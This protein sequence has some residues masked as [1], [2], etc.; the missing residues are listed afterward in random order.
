MQ[1]DKKSIFLLVGIADLMLSYI[2]FTGQQYFSLLAMLCIIGIIL[3]GLLMILLPYYYR[4]EGDRSKHRKQFATLIA[5]SL[6]SITL[7]CYESYYDL[8]ATNFS[9][10][11]INSL[12]FILPETLIFIAGL[13]LVKRKVGLKSLKSYILLIILLLIISNVL[14]SI[15]AYRLITAKWLGSDEL[16][17]N[18]YASYLFVH[19]INPYT[20]SMYPVLK[21]YN[22]S[23]TY[24]LNGSCEC[25]YGY[26]AL[27]FILP[28]AITWFS[29]D[30]LYALIFTTMVLI[31]F[32]TYLIYKK[33]E[34]NTYILLPIAAW[35][36]ASSYLTPAPLDKYL[37][38]SLFLVLAYVFRK[39][40]IVSSILSGLAASTHPISWF[41]L[42]FFYIMTLKESGKAAMFRSILI[43]VGIFLMA[44]AY[45]IVLSP[46][47]TISSMF[48]LFFTRLQFSGPSIA[49]ILVAF[50]P[51]PYWY[52][53]LITVTVL[54]SAL[55]L[56][57]LYTD[58][59]RPLIAVAPIIIF[60]ISWRNLS[61]YISVFIPLLIAVYYLEKKD[62]IRDTMQNKKV[63]PYLLVFIIVFLAAALLYVHSTYMRSNEL[64]IMQIKS[65][66]STNQTTGISTLLAVSVNVSNNKNNPESASFYLISRYP[67]NIE[68]VPGSFVQSLP[69]NQN[70]NYTLPFYLP[71]FN[72]NTKL[73]VF[74]LSENYT[75]GVE[76]NAR[77]D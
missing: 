73:Y 76:L 39:R 19:G 46:Y 6:I 9:R 44:N 65:I 45:F 48:L 47:K 53:T 28:A 60:F 52:I 29:Q 11:I 55:A 3:M 27:S 33:S 2:L 16:A 4:P 72:S 66:A 59:L 71:Q 43:T 23:P 62:R 13:Y 75:Q 37:S 18:Y 22:M 68:Y 57:Y 54:G 56:F 1:I 5:L 7:L 58:T 64:R 63:I 42:P 31:T 30:Y 8:M 69:G 34:N 14:Y 67:N 38:V 70:Y 40:L 25:A 20:A 74:V 21:T 24:E 26:P 61:S 10:I 51:V 35:F 36:A 17:F 12:T 15:Q 32:I 50:Y 49:Q 77:H 41:A